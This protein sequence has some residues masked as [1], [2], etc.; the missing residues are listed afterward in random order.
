MA[1]GPL[2]LADGQTLPK[3]PSD[4]DHQSVVALEHDLSA[5]HRRKDVRLTPAH[6]LAGFQ[7]AVAE[8]LAET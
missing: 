2:G 6:S 3:D 5:E 7:R 1:C 4:H 8:T